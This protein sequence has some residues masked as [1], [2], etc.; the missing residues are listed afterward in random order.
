MSILQKGTASQKAFT[1]AT[2]KDAVSLRTESNLILGSIRRAGQ[3][4]VSGI[5]ATCPGPSM[6][7]IPSET[8]SAG[9]QASRA[10]AGAEPF[11]V[12]ILKVASR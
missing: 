7:S 9:K 3:E 6:K 4:S 5:A 2:T 8:F 12:S 10:V 1:F 11:R